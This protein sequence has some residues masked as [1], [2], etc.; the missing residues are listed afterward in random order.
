[1]GVTLLMMQRTYDAENLRC[2]ELKHRLLSQMLLVMF[3]YTLDA[4][5]THDAHYLLI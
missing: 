5:Y 3:Y 4:H 1:M 2:K